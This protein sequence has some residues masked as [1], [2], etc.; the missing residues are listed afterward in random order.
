LF[1]KERSAEVLI[2][3]GA[4][5]LDKGGS[6]EVAHLLEVPEQTDLRDIVEEPALV[7]SL[8]RRVVAMA[9]DQKIPITFDPIVTYD[10]A[11]TIYEISQRLHCQWIV[12][13]WGGKHIGAFTSHDPIG[14]LRSHLQCNLAI[15]RD[16]GVRYVRKILVLIRGNSNDY[17][18]LETAD[19]LAGFYKAD[20]TLMKFVGHKKDEMGINHIKVSL[21]KQAGQLE[22]PS[23]VEI[24][25][26][27]KG[28]SIIQG[29]QEVTAEYDLMV[30]GA[31]EYRYLKNIIEN[32]DDNIYMR[33]VCSVVSV[34]NCGQS[35][36]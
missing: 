22:H 33:A 19:H 29:I 27:E 10:R 9:V 8:R 23:Y 7:K 32:P 5:F 15:F 36:F 25:P 31:S 12:T 1:G 11:K 34:E 6:L 21:E 20:I 35:N 16:V 14:W 2:G 26:L 24:R 17:L 30:F 4:G 18:A 13:E 3:L 28:Q